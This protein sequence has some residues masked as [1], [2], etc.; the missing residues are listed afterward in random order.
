MPIFAPRIRRRKKRVFSASTAAYAPPDVWRATL[1]LGVPPVAALTLPCRLD[2]PPFAS[3]TCAAIVWLSV[4][5]PRGTLRRKSGGSDGK[6]GRRFREIIANCRC[7]FSFC[8]RP[9]FFSCSLDNQMLNL[10]P[11]PTTPPQA[12]N[13]AAK[14][15]AAKKPAV[16][17]PAAKKPAA[18]SK[19][20]RKRRGTKHRTEIEDFVV[21]FFSFFSECSL[22][23]SSLFLPSSFLCLVGSR[24][25]SPLLFP[26]SLP[27]RSRSG[28]FGPFRDD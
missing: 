18:K 12:K 20:G 13:P 9:F 7:F 17:K 6:R 22:A 1:L 15:P 14:K 26:I 19:F 16:K 5:T 3:I 24:P 25:T 28:D 11:P 8:F 23:L 27:T 2:R 10:D 21:S 4:H